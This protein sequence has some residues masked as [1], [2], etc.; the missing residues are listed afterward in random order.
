MTETTASTAAPARPGVEQLVA[1][2]RDAMAQCDR[3]DLQRRLSEALARLTRQA[4][5]VCVVGEFKQGKSSLIN[6]VLGGEAC[7]VDD[8]LATSAITVIA[9]RDSPQVVVHRRVNGKAVAE[10]VDHR[11][12]RSYVTEA[13][14]PDNERAVERVEIGIKHRLLASGL[15]LVDSPGMGSLGSGSSAATIAFLPYADALIF[16]SDA[17]AELSAPE[18]EFL[19]TATDLCPTVLFCMTKTDLYPSWRRIAEIN[20]EHLRRAGANATIV[21]VSSAL[22]LAAFAAA[23]KD[24]ARESG[25][26]DLLGAIDAGVLAKAKERAIE[27]A[28]REAAGALEQVQSGYRSERAVL[29]DPDGGAA[30]LAALESAKARLEHLRG[31]A[32]RWSVTLNDRM[33]DISAE[34]SHA[35]RGATR[36]ITRSL[37]ERVESLSSTEDWEALARALQTEVSESVAN[38]FARVDRSAEQTRRE[39]VELLADEVEGVQATFGE[40]KKLDITTLWTDRPEPQAKGLAAGVMS[41]VS[42]LRGAQS[43][44][45]MFGMM[46][47]LLPAAAGAVLLSNPVTLGLGALFAGQALLEQRKRKL[48]AQRQQSKAA[49]RQFLDEVQFEVGNELS[50]LIRTVQRQLRD[51]FTE[52]LAELQR[53]ATDAAKRAAESAAQDAASRERRVKDLD[54][55]IQVLQGL[56]D[57]VQAALAATK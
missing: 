43:G 47:R 56:R 22:R 25:F 16:T 14:N 35:F 3:P 29:A 44:M 39:I 1:T 42:V 2:A 37:E 46:G 19:R 26:G 15:T 40:R 54:N 9:Y 5:V 28:L 21:P 23:D 53:T 6:A 50:E 36:T 51:E 7:P 45:M 31:P 18:V 4:T 49:A 20:A 8:D 24:L 34:S 27:R 38:V 11:E 13:G 48:T 57:E 41:G 10:V 12:L 33:A 30:A 32:A 52:R 17:S 55:R